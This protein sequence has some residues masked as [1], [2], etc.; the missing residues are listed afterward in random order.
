L[1]RDLLVL[2]MHTGLQRQPAGSRLLRRHDTALGEA[3]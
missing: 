2:P 3:G 1:L